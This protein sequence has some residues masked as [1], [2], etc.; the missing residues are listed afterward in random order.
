MFEYIDLFKERNEKEKRNGS[1]RKEM[2][3]KMESLQQNAMQIAFMDCEYEWRKKPK[4]NR[5]IHWTQLL[6]KL[7]LLCIQISKSCTFFSSFI[8]SHATILCFIAFH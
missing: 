1:E 6:G 8:L 3:I 5:K 2:K 4:E 7:S